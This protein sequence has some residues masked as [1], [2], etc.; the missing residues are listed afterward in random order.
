MKASV[1]GAEKSD[2]VA[3][4]EDRKTGR[5]QPGRVLCFVPRLVGSL[6]K[7]LHFTGLCCG[8][9]KASEGSV[10]LLGDQMGHEEAKEGLG[11]HLRGCDGV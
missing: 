5:G 7:V 6:W 10:W 2:G 9:T 8:L 1:V 3:G 11:Q 4:Q